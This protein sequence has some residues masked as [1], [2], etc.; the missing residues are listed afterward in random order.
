MPPPPPIHA[1][2]TATLYVVNTDLSG[3]AS[4]YTSGGVVYN[5]QTNE[6]L[7]KPA[8]ASL[9]NASPGIMKFKAVFEQSGVFFG[10]FMVFLVCDGD[11]DGLMR[12]QSGVMVRKLSV[13]VSRI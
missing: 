12:F 1:D 11:P 4:I 7:V 10:A 6:P 5:A 3:T 8:A 2:T 9:L 13:P